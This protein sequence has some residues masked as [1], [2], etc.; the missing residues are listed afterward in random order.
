MVATSSTHTFTLSDLASTAALAAHLAATA[1]PGDCFLLDGPVGVGKTAFARAFIQT[2]I[3]SE[4]D[5]PSPTFTLVQMYDAP[6]FE[7]W[8]CDLYRLSSADELVELGL[9]EAF[10]QAVTLIE[11]PDR[12]G[13]LA[14]ASAQRLV[15]EATGQE[16]RRLTVTGDK[17][18]ASLRAAA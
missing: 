13:G 8:H 11:W 15:F 16:T 2:L 18:W 7:I 5:V 12:L 9:D 6:N 14:P 3:A 17:R 10:G 4:E 1:K